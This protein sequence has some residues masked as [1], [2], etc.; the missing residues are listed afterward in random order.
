M[1]SA[2]DLELVFQFR[3]AFFFCHGVLPHLGK[4]P[5]YAYE[6]NETEFVRTC[7]HFCLRRVSLISGKNGFIVYIYVEGDEIPIGQRYR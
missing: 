2:P 6:M 1:Q 5:A 7:D 3:F 4:Y